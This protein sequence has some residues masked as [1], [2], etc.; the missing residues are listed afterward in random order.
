MTLTIFISAK[1]FTCLNRAVPVGSRSK[2]VLAQAV[3][4]T[5]KFSAGNYALACDEPEA[6]NLLMYARGRCPGA[7]ASIV[8][9]FKTAALVAE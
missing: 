5:S 2:Q 7:A 1:E 4:L 3:Q 6:R 9:A 8:E